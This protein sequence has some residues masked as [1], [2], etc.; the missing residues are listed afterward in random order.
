MRVADERHLHLPFLVDVHHPLTS[1]VA[2]RRSSVHPYSL[3]MAALPLPAELQFKTLTVHIAGGVADS[4]KL[5]MLNGAEPA[6]LL[7]AVRG[8]VGP[9]ISPASVFFT[10]GPDASGIV[11]PLSSSLP[12]GAVLHLHGRGVPEVALLPSTQDGQTPRTMPAPT[13]RDTPRRGRSSENLRRRSPPRGGGGGRAE[14]ETTESSSWSGANTGSEFE[15]HLTSNHVEDLAASMVGPLPGDNKQPLLSQ[16]LREEATSQPATHT[17]ATASGDVGTSETEMQQKDMSR[18]KRSTSAMRRW[19]AGA[20]P[21]RRSDEEAAE[22]RKATRE[23]VDAIQRFSRLSTDLANERTL[24]AWMRTC[25]AC[26]RTVFAFYGLEGITDLWTLT[27]FTGEWAMAFLIILTATMGHIRYSKM[28][29]VIRLKE[30][31]LDFH[32]CSLRWVYYIIMV[33]A[34]VATFGSVAQ[35]WEK[36]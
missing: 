23:T 8:R 17:A 3:P 24:L 16:L 1:A 28:K 20:L 9:G 7:D 12:N 2:S 6:A 14:P 22:D 29:E 11:V 34:C 36:A 13:T 32:R 4:F 5:A 33:A 30:P 10:S 26:V 18:R 15:T 31:P 21:W 27:V 19:A 25:L 35:V